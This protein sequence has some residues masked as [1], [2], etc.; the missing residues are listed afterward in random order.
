MNRRR[1]ATLAVLFTTLLGGTY[2]ALRTTG[3]ELP[4]AATA[5]DTSTAPPTFEGCA[6]VWASQALPDVS[7]EFDTAVR[8][9]IPEA[10]GGAQAYGENCVYGDGHA[11]FGAMETDFYVS[12]DVPD[13]ND[14]Q[15]LGDEMAK[16]MVMVLK[17]FPRRV[18]PV[19]RTVLWSSR[20]TLAHRNLSLCPSR[21]GVIEN[22]P[23]V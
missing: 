5:T 22:K 10:T 1:A 18:C 17:R 23:R 16:I 11:T 20:S 19:A 15:A 14:E 4:T 12:L 6:Y 13:L 8:E 7:A 9:L 3:P 21:S 2:A